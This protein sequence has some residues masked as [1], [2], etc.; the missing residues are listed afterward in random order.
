MFK[1]LLLSSLLWAGA[2][3]QI[4]KD[5]RP[6]VAGLWVYPAKLCHEYYHFGNN[7]K[8]TTYSGQEKTS[9][10]YAVVQ[11]DKDS[12]PLL[13]LFTDYDNNAPDCDGRQV[14][15]SKESS[16]FFVQLDSRQDPR[17]MQWC[18]DKDGQRCFLELKRVLP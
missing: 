8:L 3:E 5:E 7:G 16:A 2:D 18:E 17:Q 15:Q 14:N 1:S 6:L 9:G 13:L 12:L 10:K 4:I 11:K